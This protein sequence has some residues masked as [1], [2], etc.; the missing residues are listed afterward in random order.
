MKE[1]LFEPDA[2]VAH[3]LRALAID[4]AIHPR[5]QPHLSAA[6][7]LVCANGRAY[8]IADDE[9]HLAVFSED[10]PFGEL[11]QILPGGLPGSKSKRKKRKPDFESLL[12]LP[13]HGAR[14]GDALIAFGSGSRPNRNGGVVIPLDAECERWPA[15]RFF[16]LAPLYEPLVGLLGEINIEGAMVTDG[17]MVLLN[18]GVAGTT[19]SIVLRYPLRVL[20]DLIHGQASLVKPISMRHFLLPSIEGVPVGFTDGAAL[21]DGRWLFTA[22]AEHTGDSYADGPC[23]GS[24]VG[25]VSAQDDL[26]ALH[27]LQPPVKVEGIDAR[28]DEQGIAI[29]MVTDTDNPTHSSWLYQARLYHLA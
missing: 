9:H 15:V 5:G 1:S 19:E 24:A 4:P 7:G 18:R 17:D 12:L 3:P 6:S 13:A 21:P 10:Q 28:V 16:D 26:L 29:C 27:R 23:I 20:H 11:H 25:L 14:A 2:L 22:V 8:V